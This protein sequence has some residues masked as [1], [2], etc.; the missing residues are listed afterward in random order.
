MVYSFGMENI[1]P[2]S[3]LRDTSKVEKDLKENGGRLYITKNGYSDL[4]IL[5]PDNYD[6]IASQKIEKP[7]AGDHKKYDRKSIDTPQCNPLGFVRCRAQSIEVDVANVTANKNKILQAVKESAEDG[8][9]VLCLPELC[10]TGYTCGDLFFSDNLQ[11]KVEK[12][13]KEIENESLAYD[14]FFAFGAPIVQNNSLYNCA[15][16]VYKGKILGIVPKSFLPNYGEF[17]E[18]RHFAPALKENEKI[19]VMGVSYPFGTKLIFCDENYLKLKIGIEICEDAWIPETPSTKAALAGADVILNLSASNEIVGKREYRS[20]LVSMTSARLCAA[21]VYADAGDG[22]STTDL[23]FG[24]HNLIAENGKILSE[25][26][27][28]EMGKAT[29]EIDL[30]KI[31]AERI[32]MTT[33]G[34]AGSDYYQFIFFSMLLEQPQ[35][36]LRHYSANP[37]VPEGDG[38]DLK[39]VSL[40]LK[41][42]EMG[43][44]KRLST[45]HTKKALVGVS[46]GLDSTLALL[47]TVEAFKHLKYDLRGITAVTIPAFGTSK[48]TYNNGKKLADELGVSFREI[49]IKK[50][51]VSHFSDIGHDLNEY[52]VT[53]ENAQAR[54]RT[55]V[56]M[57]LA[58]DEG[59]IMVGTSDLSELC[60]GWTTFNGD[61]MSMY[62][63]NASI[64]KTL[65]RYLCEG[66]AILH[67]ETLDSITDIVSTPISPELLPTGKNGNI[68]QKTE[69]KIGPYEL[70]DFFIFHFLR[71]GF[72]PTKLYFLAKTAYKGK[73]D[74]QTIKKWLKEF[75]IRFFHNQFKRS[76]LP[77]GAKVGTVA[78][79]PRGDLRMPSDASADDYLREIESL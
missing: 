47:V 65:V 33:F 34:N 11:E 60:L 44:A 71:F 19:D 43:L 22:E 78:V 70:N 8:V 2:I 6:K 31:T 15:V 61:H 55:Q 21:Y 3:I 56:L 26:Q 16:A 77:D 62:G 1:K 48:R 42:Q 68:A 59:A 76:C 53:Y 79:S 69:D 40:I 39:R 50:T 41:I 9:K 58:N 54:E 23:V 36:L 7:C 14:V 49:N 73:Y 52:N 75:F 51:L 64:P 35:N 20:S 63:V 74:D 13:L 38:I 29:T 12:S 24:S 66:Y 32:K 4:V 67:P 45:I 27:L 17:Y 37:F 5:S 72:D 28:F 10:L 46:G 25:T 18:K 30:E 57:D